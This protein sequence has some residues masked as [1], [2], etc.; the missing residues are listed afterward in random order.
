M[1]T[2]AGLVAIIVVGLTSPGM[3]YDAAFFQRDMARRS[4]CLATTHSEPSYESC[5]TGTPAN[6]KAWTPVAQGGSPSR[7]TSTGRVF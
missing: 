6:P 7:G 2:K 3:A 5:V 1:I 4:H